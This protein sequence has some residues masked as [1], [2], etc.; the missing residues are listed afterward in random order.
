MT[1]RIHDLAGM[2]IVSSGMVP[3]DTAVF[4]D[5][6]GGITQFFPPVKPVTITMKLDSEALVKTMKAL[7]HGFQTAGHSLMALRRAV[8]PKEDPPRPL[9]PSW[10]EMG[11]ID[12][13]DQ[14][15]LRRMYTAR[16]RAHRRA[17]RRRRRQRPVPRF[18][19]HERFV[20][21]Y[22]PNTVIHQR[23]DGSL[24]AQL[25]AYKPTD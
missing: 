4:V 17:L 19:N 11:L 12:P 6:K 14:A 13:V 1:D 23:P 15:R 3:P 22:A 9:K 25:L 20:E 21:M 2:R 18:G 5:D 16:L 7:T 8:R 24:E 10:F